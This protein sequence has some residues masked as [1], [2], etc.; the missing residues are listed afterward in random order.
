MFHIILSQPMALKNRILNQKTIPTLKSMSSVVKFFLLSLCLSFLSSSI[1]FAQ[2]MGQESSEEPVLNEKK[3]LS[4]IE[5]GISFLTLEPR[6][7]NN[8][9]GFIFDLNRNN[10]AITLHQNPLFV[11]LDYSSASKNNV[12]I[13]FL[14]LG[15][16]FD[17]PIGFSTKG[18]FTPLFPLS[19]YSDFLLSSIPDNIESDNL[20]IS[21]LGIGAGIGFNY[22]PKHFSFGAK[23]VPVY[24]FS[25][26][27][28]SAESGSSKGITFNSWLVFHNILNQ[29]GLALGYRYKY[30]VTD[31]SEN[32]FNYKVNMSAITLGVSF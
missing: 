3:S 17:I 24:A 30:I 4:S 18:L 13:K 8:F 2:I 14:N 29:Y 7:S 32:R 27:A 22:S 5:A 25:T 12:D 19:I 11:F 20:S 9:D 15:V 28:F 16:R 6:N 10:L 23:L 26:Q 1:G 31:F 21:S